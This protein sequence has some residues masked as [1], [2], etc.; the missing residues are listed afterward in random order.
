MP[1][2]VTAGSLIRGL[3]YKGLRCRPVCFQVPWNCNREN[4]AQA[5]RFKREDV[6]QKWVLRQRLRNCCDP[7]CMLLTDPYD[8]Q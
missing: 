5:F 1:I 7:A 3:V 2:M 4:L 6:L 8:L